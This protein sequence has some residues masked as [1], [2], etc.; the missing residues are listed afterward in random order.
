MKILC[1]LED[2]AE[3]LRVE[4]NLIERWMPEANYVHNPENH[5]VSDTSIWKRINTALKAKRALGEDR[6]PKEQK[7]TAKE[8]REEWLEGARARLRA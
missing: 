7:K 3:A 8:L 4:K 2:R 5:S 6:P 1:I